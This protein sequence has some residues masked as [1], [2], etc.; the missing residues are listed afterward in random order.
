MTTT[1]QR[2]ALV[3]GATGGIGGEAASALVRHGWTVRALTRRAQPDRAGIDW[4][5]GDAMV[6]ADVA[7]A[8]Q[9]VQLIVHAANPP[10]Y[11]NWGKLVLP[12]LDSTIA[13]AK[14][15]GARILLPGTVY[16]FGLETF[17]LVD[18]TA[19]QNPTTRKG[20]IR[21]EME[22]RLKA[23]SAQGAPVLIVRA[24]D[25]F[26]PHA[27]NNWFGQAVVKSGGPVRS[28]TEPAARGVA[29][30]WAYLPDLAETMA[31]LLD[32]ADRLAAFEVFH[33][34]GHRLGWGEMAASVRRAAGQ[35][36]LPVTGFP[37]WLVVALSPVVPLF[38][39]MA[40]M[41]YLWREPLALDDRKLRAFLGDVP[42]TPL[43]AAVAASLRGLGCLEVSDPLPT[44]E[45]GVRRAAVGG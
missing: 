29:H 7:R 15:Q 9:G 41:R 1:Q 35:P 23:A 3:I 2:I 28:V 30:A 33:F 43:D 36:K 39:E 6:A 16:N 37:W 27:S 32:R 31:Q 4:I 14:A 18:E 17:P 11:R 45:G 22:R 21:V 24:G 19:P 34:G 42:H 13:A 8:A 12:M 26:G 5:R 40:E 44:G 20:K 10:G 25:F 38:H